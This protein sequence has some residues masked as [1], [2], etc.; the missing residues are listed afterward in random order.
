MEQ[1]LPLVGAAVPSIWLETHRDWFFSEQRD[2]EIQDFAMPFVLDDANVNNHVATLKTMLDGYTGRLGIHAPFWNLSLAAFDPKIRAVVVDR[3]K[4][5]LDIAAELG[6]THMVIHS[7]LEFLGMPESLTN[8][9]IG[10]ETVFNVTHK[11]LAEI[12]KRAEEMQCTLVIENIFDQRPLML[13]EL[14]K[15]FAS[16][17]VRQSLD[18]GHA[19]IMHKRGAPPPDYFAREAGELLAHVHLQDT[20]GYTDRHWTVGE[21]QIDWHGLFEVLHT[22][23]HKP[24]LILELRDYAAIPQA[25]QWLADHGLVR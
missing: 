16:E 24:R 2:L 1:T 13:T 14:V 20:D 3:L 22:M 21:G 12:V 7:P 4:Q 9:R 18:V 19:Y 25:A 23:E 8:P 10:N 17:S 15:S 6:A 5:S 11:T